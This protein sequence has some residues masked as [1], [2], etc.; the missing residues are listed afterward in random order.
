MFV[1]MMKMMMIEKTMY[2]LPTMYDGV[3]K[4]VG[5]CGKL[6]VSFENQE[7]KEHKEC[8][9]LLGKYYIRLL[10]AARAFLEKEHN[11]WRVVK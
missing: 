11:K 6:C 3:D 5:K 1:V 4:K 2:N 8:K 7:W 9:Y 10:F